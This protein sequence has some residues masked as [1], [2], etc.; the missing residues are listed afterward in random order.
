[1]FSKSLRVRCWYHKLGNIRSKLPAEA[2]DEV[3]AH[4]RSVRY[5]ATYEAGQAAAAAA[6]D[7]FSD[8]FPVGDVVF[9]R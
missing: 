4:V 2:A 9:G 8:R 3:L 5:M 1:M 6:I 7:K